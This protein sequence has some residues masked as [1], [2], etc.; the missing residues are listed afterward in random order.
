MQH[1][2]NIA[3]HVIELAYAIGLLYYPTCSYDTYIKFL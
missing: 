2:T 1:W 3:R